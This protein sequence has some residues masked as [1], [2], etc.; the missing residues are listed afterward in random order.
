MELSYQLLINWRHSFSTKTFVLMLLLKEALKPQAKDCEDAGNDR[1]H[2]GGCLGHGRVNQPSDR[3]D[4]G[5]Q[6]RQA[7]EK[8]EQ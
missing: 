8:L 5:K 7:K 2:D 6:K 1:R 3:R 4:E